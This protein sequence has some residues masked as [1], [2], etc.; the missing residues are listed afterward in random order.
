MGHKIPE[1]LEGDELRL[2]QILINLVKNALKFTINGFIWIY[3]AYD[4]ENGLI[5]IHVVDTGKGI[6]PGD[7]AKLFK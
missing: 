6:K 3:M 5:K 7:H 4:S 2:K 1:V